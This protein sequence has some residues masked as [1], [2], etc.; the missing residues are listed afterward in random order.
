MSV[1]RLLRKKEAQNKCIQSMQVLRMW[2][3]GIGETSKNVPI[4]RVSGCLWRWAVDFNIIF[5]FCFRSLVC[6]IILLMS[7]VLLF[8]I[9]FLV[10][11]FFVFVLVVKTHQT[12]LWILRV[13]LSRYFI[14]AYVYVCQVSPVLHIT[15]LLHY[16]SVSIHFNT[17][18]Y[19]TVHSVRTKYMQVVTVHPVFLSFVCR[20]LLVRRISIIYTYKL[21]IYRLSSPFASEKS[22]TMSLGL[23]EASNGWFSQLPYRWLIVSYTQLTYII[24]S[25]PL[26]IFFRIF[27]PFP[28]IISFYHDFSTPIDAYPRKEQISR[29]VTHTDVSPTR[30][31]P[32][33]YASAGTLPFFSFPFSYFPYCP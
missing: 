13:L 10:F 15:L 27:T 24:A 6:D 16:V 3:G 20:Y 21:H 33:R 8:F 19:T 28:T 30:G 31:A 23:F 14:F 1:S 11:C 7:R 22:L 9:F 2:Q 25:S 17:Q 18:R 32:W 12:S 5:V 4:R 26:T 29:R